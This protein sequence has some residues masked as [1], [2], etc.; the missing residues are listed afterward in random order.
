MAEPKTVT[1]SVEEYQALLEK[2][3]APAPAITNAQGIELDALGAAIA[4]GIADADEKLHPHEKTPNQVDRRSVFNPEG[5]RLKP[6]PP[7]KCPM[8]YG[9]AP[10]EAQTMTRAE[11]VACNG[12][13]PGHYR[14]TRLDRS[15]ALFEVR[16]QR[17]SQLK[18]E[19]LWLLPP[20]DDPAKNLYPPL[21]E[22]ARQCCAAN[23]V[24]VAA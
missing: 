9:S 17:N 7:L 4:R 10:L 1:V 11:I 20:K 16:A 12:L 24:T 18:V 14:V 2:A 22:L 19:K 15:T 21:D 3:T 5:D 13:E 8:F 23:A 6:R